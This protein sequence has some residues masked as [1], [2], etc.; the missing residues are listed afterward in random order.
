MNIVI[1]G[2]SCSGKSTFANEIENSLHFEED[3]YFKD[4]KDIP[5]L[6]SGYLFDSINSFYVNEIKNDVSKLLRD[7]SV[8][9][10][11]YDVIGNR[12][13][14]KNRIVYSKKLNVFEGLH[15]I[16]ILSFLNDS[17]SIFIDTDLDLCLKRRIL[18]DRKYGIDEDEII[19]YFNE[20][21][22]P[23]YECYI[24]PQKYCCDYVVRGDEDKLCLLK[25]FQSY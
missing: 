22:I 16:N 19:R 4:K 14:D 25:K 15:M 1:S 13:V 10:P 2:M 24:L 11:N 12:R 23:M 20:V 6:K 17:F 9:V 8:Y 21:M 3:W 5:F 18:R 7:G